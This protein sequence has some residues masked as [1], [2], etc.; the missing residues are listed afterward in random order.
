MAPKLLRV[1]KPTNK[2]IHEIQQLLKIT[3]KRKSKLDNKLTL[4]DVVAEMVYHIVENEILQPPY[5][6]CHT[7]LQNTKTAEN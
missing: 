6:S 5:I 1:K 7:V 3:P 4:S 2:Q